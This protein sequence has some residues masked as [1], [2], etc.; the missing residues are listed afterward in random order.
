MKNIVKLSDA[1]AYAQ[2]QDPEP[3]LRFSDRLL[4]AFYSSHEEEEGL[5]YS[6]TATADGLYDTEEG[7][8]KVIHLLQPHMREV[9]YLLGGRVDRA[10]ENPERFYTKEVKDRRGVLRLSVD[11]YRWRQLEVR[12]ERG[13]LRLSVTNIE[14]GYNKENGF[15]LSIYDAHGAERFV[16][17]ENGEY[18]LWDAS[19]EFITIGG[20]IPEC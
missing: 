16:V 6:L 3:L 10:T 18:S 15:V 7:L 8:E 1:L 14:W 20:F 12:D 11:L 9:R 4:D 2:G 17:R 13:V 19:G 5:L